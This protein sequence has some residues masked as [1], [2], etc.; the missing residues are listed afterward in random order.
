MIIPQRLN[1]L[2]VE[3]AGESVPTE[4]QETDY[5]HLQKI[6]NKFLLLYNFNK[7]DFLPKLKGQTQAKKLMR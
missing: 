3:F 1:L 4:F 6:Q 5:N 2:T 7:E